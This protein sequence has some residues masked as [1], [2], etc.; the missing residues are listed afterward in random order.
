MDGDDIGRLPLI[1]VWLE[2]IYNCIN[3]IMSLNPCCKQQKFNPTRNKS[4][5]HKS[6]L[7]VIKP[8]QP[9]LVN[10]GKKS[11]GNNY[12]HKRLV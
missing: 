8:F 5:L 2:Q 9:I 11:S 10:F 4:S 7:A 3:S 6:I 12:L 1:Q